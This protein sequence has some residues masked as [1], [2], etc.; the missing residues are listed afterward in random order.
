MLIS[1]K[2]SQEI[3]ND[4]GETRT[5]KARQ[6]IKQG[7]VTIT[8][9][10]YE[11]ENNFSLTSIIKGNYGNYKVNIDVQ[12]GE[13]EVAS[14]ECQD[15]QNYYS[16]CK[17]IVA[18]LMKFEQTK[19]WDNSYQDLDDFESFED[20]NFDDFIQPST[21]PESNKLK[22]KSFN[23]LINTF[24]ND[25]L[26]QL[27]KDTT[28]LY[29]EQNKLRIE[30]KIDFD[31]FSTGLKLEI[32]IGNTRM[33]KIK[34]LPEFYTRMSTNDFFRYGEKLEF[35]HNRNNFQ[36]D[37]IPLL[38]FILKYAEI[39]KYSSLDNRYGYYY[40][41]SLNQSSI[42][43]GKN[44]IDEAFDLLKNKNVIFNYDYTKT[45]LELIE[46]SPNIEF[47]LSKINDNE[48]TLRP[49]IDIFKIEIFKGNNYDYLLY[50]N[51][52]YRCDKE[53]S[54]TTLRIVQTFRENYTSE[55]LLQKEN[56]KDFYS[57][58]MPKIENSVKLQGI[59]KEEIEQYRP[60]K[61]A[62]KV[63]LD[64][65]END[66]LIADIKFCYSDEEFNP[67]ESDIK[68]K[69][70]RNELEETKNLN[71]FKQ[72]GFMLDTN[73]L[74][75]ILPND[76]QIYKFLSDDINFYMQKFEVLVTETFKSK[77][78]K[79]ARLG[80]VGVR[81][82][83]DLLNIDLSKLN[84]SPSEIEEVMEKYKLKKKFHRL[85]NGSF[86][87]L[88][89]N[90]DIE[91]LER[92]SSGM[93][94]KY[95]DLKNNTIKLPVNRTLY[96]NEL[97]KKFN[98]T[99]TT[100]NNEYKQIVED[101]EKGNIDEK[102]KI[103]D[104]MKNVLR[105]YQKVGYNW[106]KTLEQ[107]K[108]G[109]ILADDMGL[110]K[111]L[112]LLSVILSYIE[113]TD[114]ENRKTSIVVS[115]SSLALN[116]LAEAKKFAPQLNVKVISGTANERRQII[117]ELHKYDIII[118]SYDLLKRDIEKYQEINYNFKYIIA[119]EAQY[120]KNSNTQNAKSIKQLKAET[121]YALTGTPIENSLAE[122]WSIFDY[123]MPGYL[124][125]Y[126]KFKTM[127]ETPIVKEEN[128]DAMSK[129]KMLIEPFVLRRTKKEVLTELPEKTI[130]VLNN[131][132]NAEQEKIYMSYLVKAKQDV[133]DKINIIGFEKSQMMILA[134][135]IRLRQ[136]CCHPSLFI[137]DYKGESSKLIQC[138]E[139][140]EDAISAGHKIL[141]FSSY[142]SIFDI[143]Q[144]EL[145][146][147][148]INYFKLTGN[149]KVSERIS[150]VDEFN[151][152]PDIKIFLISLKAGGTGLNL[153]GA[154]MVIHYDPWWNVSSEN[155]ATDRAY[156]I[157]QKNNVQVYKLITENSIEEKIYELQEKKAKLVDNMLSTKVSF[158]SKLSKD[159][160]L[161][162][163][164]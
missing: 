21:K 11:N 49:N 48:L 73:N 83:N 34:D 50:A 64:F 141:L 159:E 91:F 22:Y 57:I 110:G 157:G 108:F 59:L 80:S 153:T 7:K 39:M 117:V 28:T 160:I 95:K 145:S 67:L 97:L 36:E 121:K 16:A 69:S 56:L 156:R 55:M 99:Q 6:Y 133:A 5:S 17:H 126:K 123:I 60:E 31:K 1:K 138:L 45:T 114:K 51:K 96:L 70:L 107:Y 146:K 20:N 93:D 140:I 127:Y 79:D 131:T 29:S 152:N 23:N 112:Q 139:I 111:T 144:K 54:N 128:Q 82:E 142:T 122:L 3:Y 32:K 161:N 104:D 164:E 2:L 43:L 38:D 37:Y 143:I 61:L 103:P 78:I 25:E 27:N 100:K 102:I 68:I 116:W 77:E 94:I 47:D 15:Y 119:D 35:V 42:T 113:A 76:E 33:Y 124:F 4:A 10:D 130:T 41:S 26:N 154:D 109:G 134:A 136:I 148:S 98:S 158:I 101:L 52:L 88:S 151:T 118:T 62:V 120:L 75:F 147:R 30:P 106:L 87:D 46:Q 44:A 137:S 63:F 150:L 24:Y 105:D 85:K 18:T 81:V 72:S 149:T 8:K 90:E 14:C 125:Q 162:L 65:D 135:L 129:L 19:Y 9:S 74:R 13:L 92:L 84:I 40:T 12:K 163:F 71:I 115:P 89:Q 58:I 86:L 155:Q 132:M 53:F 66:F